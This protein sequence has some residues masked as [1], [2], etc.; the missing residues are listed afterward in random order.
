MTAELAG[1]ALVANELV[2]AVLAAIIAVAWAD[3]A[4]DGWNVRNAAIDVAGNWRHRGLR[5]PDQY[6]P[7]ALSLA[8][9]LM[10]CVPAVGPRS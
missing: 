3:L 6:L 2:A 1:S 9:L 8:S 7:I 5:K 4:P 10:G